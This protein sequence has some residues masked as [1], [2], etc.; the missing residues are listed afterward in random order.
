MNNDKIKSV[1]SQ[2]LGEG[3][4]IV[5]EDGVLSPMIEWV[6]WVQQS[7]EEG[8]IKVDVQ[9]S[10]ESSQVFDKDVKLNQIWH[11]DA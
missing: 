10:D 8:D 9:F 4:R 2:N 1:L 11:E 7:D 6:D 5:T 3:Y